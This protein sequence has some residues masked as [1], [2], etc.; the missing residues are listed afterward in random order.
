MTDAEALI[1]SRAKREILTH[2]IRDAEGAA[3]M[4]QAEAEE[5]QSLIQETNARSTTGTILATEF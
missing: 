5:L 2:V 3:S 1:R 4:A